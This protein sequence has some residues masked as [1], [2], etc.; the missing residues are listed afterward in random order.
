MFC[1]AA[2]RKNCS[3]TNANLPQAPA[4]Q[5]DGSHRIRSNAKGSLQ[6]TPSK[7]PREHNL[8][9]HSSSLETFPIGIY[10]YSGVVLSNLNQNRAQ[11]RNVTCE[12][13]AA[14][15]ERVGG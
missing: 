15:V 2:S 10:R 13:G 7:L 12:L 3:R 11:G 5:S 4:T 8:R 1:A 14:G 9:T 6:T